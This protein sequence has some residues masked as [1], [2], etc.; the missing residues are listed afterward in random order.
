MSKRAVIVLHHSD[1]V[2]PHLARCLDAVLRNQLD[3]SYH[4]WV[5]SDAPSKIERLPGYERFTFIEDPDIGCSSQKINSLVPTLS[6]E[7]FQTLSVISDDVVVGKRCIQGMCEASE[8]FGSIVSALTN[9]EVGQ[10]VLMGIMLNN[11][12]QHLL[13]HGA[14]PFEKA[15]PF[16]PAVHDLTGF[17]ALVREPW[18]SFAIYAMPLRLWIDLDGTDINLE[19]RHNDEDFCYRASRRGAYSYIALFA[20]ALHYGSATLKDS[21]L[22][23]DT[24]KKCTEEFMRKRTTYA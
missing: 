8:Q 7:G 13:F 23:L 11:G 5:I 15:E 19:Y 6:K 14:I 1:H 2:K 4:C 9:T 17:H 22:L 24:K 21:P 20:L 3:G 10:N 16:I 18:V 12:D